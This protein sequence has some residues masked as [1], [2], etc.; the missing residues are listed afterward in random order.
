[1]RTKGII[2]RGGEGKRKGMNRRE[3]GERVKKHQIDERTR[4][5]SGGLVEEA[6]KGKPW[7]T[8]KITKMR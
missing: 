5:I 7:V 4:D 8:G 1:L 6:E 2:Q 3:R